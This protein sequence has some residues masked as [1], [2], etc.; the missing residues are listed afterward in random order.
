MTTD[1]LVFLPLGGCGEIG[2]NLNAYGY[3]PPHARRWIVV[4][5]GVTFGETDTPG[6]RPDL[7]GPGLS[8]RRAYRCGVPDARARGPYRRY[9]PAVPAAAD[10][11]ADLCHAVHCR[12]GAR[13]A[14]E[15]GVDTKRLKTICAGRLRHG[16][17]VHRAL[18]DADALD[19][20]AE[21]ARDPT[22]RWA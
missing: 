20:R 21:C 14:A 4:D 1:E 16:R 5:V 15:R 13:Q 18:R 7:R 11:G 22:R 9:R 6:D 10:Q 3:G 19:P 8:R 12:A 2:M 17:A